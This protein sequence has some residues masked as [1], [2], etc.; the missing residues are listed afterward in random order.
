M[1][2][3]LG[4]VPV[5]LAMLSLVVVVKN[6]NGLRRYW[7]FFL[8]TTAIVATLTLGPAVSI[9]HLLP[10]L[11]FEQ[12]PWRLESLTTLSLAVL[13]GATALTLDAKENGHALNLPTVLLGIL[14]VL[15]SYS[16]LTAQ[17][18]LQAK[19]GPVSILG[20]FRFEQSAGEM[21]G[22][23]AWVKNIPDWS[24]MADVYFANKKVKTKIATTELDPNKVW[25][26]VLPD[27]I[28]FH[29]DS[30]RIA[31][32]STEDNLP[33]TFNIFYYPGWTA[34]LVKP[35]STDIIKPLK[36]QVTDDLGRIQVLVPKGTDQWL[37]LHFDDTTPRI[38]G[39]WISAG[40][41]LLALGLLIWEV[42]SQRKHAKALAAENVVGNV[43]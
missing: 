38:A 39:E 28:G 5:V 7:V 18:Q 41:I 21:T 27:G 36:I 11:A 43:A 10:F 37:Y 33:I 1:S 17:M 42:R 13:A 3:Q 15:G 24:P 19:E 4:V 40:S 25:I 20:L 30:E 2:F 8:V 22:S 12:F 32:N 31:Y 29:T 16:Y 34:Y 35:W 9:W 14:I 23:T 6:P 26:G